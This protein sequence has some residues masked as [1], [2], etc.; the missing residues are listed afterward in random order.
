MNNIGFIGISEEEKQNNWKELIFKTVIKQN[1]FSDR[2]GPEST[3]WKYTKYLEELI[4][5]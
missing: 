1:D 3:L 4:H 2:K 5:N